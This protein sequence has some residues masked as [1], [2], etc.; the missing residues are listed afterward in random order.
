M[1]I[2]LPDNYNSTRAGKHQIKKGVSRWHSN[3]DFNEE[4]LMYAGG[5]YLGFSSKYSLVALLDAHCLNLIPNTNDCE[6]LDI[7]PCNHE[8][9]K[10]ID[11]KYNGH[12]HGRNYWK[13]SDCD[14]TISKPKGWKPA[15]NFLKI[16]PK[17]KL[18]K[19]TSFMSLDD[20]FK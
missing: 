9:C 10:H 18:G 17:G 5:I 1:G 11:A 15:I 14:K 12:A 20:F 2:T 19:T 3:L 6:L 13:C 4:P 16:L 7:N 8:I